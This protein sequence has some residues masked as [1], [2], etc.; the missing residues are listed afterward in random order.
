MHLF[1]YD[2]LLRQLLLGVLGHK[3]YMLLTYVGHVS[4]FVPK[5]L[6]KKIL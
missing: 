4:K 1:I 3:L 6:Q 2:I 5:M